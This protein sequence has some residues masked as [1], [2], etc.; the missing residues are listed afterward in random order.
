MSTCHRCR[1]DIPADRTLC[2]ACEDRY[3]L[4][5]VI[6]LFSAIGVVMCLLA[7]SVWNLWKL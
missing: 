3:L 6:G 1:C 7:A 5:L 2:A 4:S